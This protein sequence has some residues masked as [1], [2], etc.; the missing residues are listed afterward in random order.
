M[1]AVRGWG[2]LGRH[3]D[4][5]G[6]ELSLADD[7]AIG[8]IPTGAELFLGKGAV[9]VGP[10]GGASA[11][12]GVVDDDS[13]YLFL[14]TVLYFHEGF[15]LD[16]LQFC[17]E[18]TKQNVGSFALLII[19]FDWTQLFPLLVDEDQSSHEDCSPS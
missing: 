13:G 7:W 5:I 9:E 18:K 8:S 11:Y 14:P 4:F 16:R 15:E 6:R 1:E 2:G 12:L 17:F 10:T 3:Y 19:V